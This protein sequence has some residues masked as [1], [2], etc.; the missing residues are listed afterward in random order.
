MESTIDKS[1]DRMKEA[2]HTDIKS[3]NELLTETLAKLKIDLV[4]NID[5]A[6]SAGVTDTEVVEEHCLKIVALTHEKLAEHVSNLHFNVDENAS[7]AK[8]FMVSVIK[9]E[10]M[11]CFNDDLAQHIKETVLEEL[12]EDAKKRLSVK[13]IKDMVLEEVKADFQEQ[14]SDH[15]K[16]LSGMSEKLNSENSSV[17]AE[18]RE[19]VKRLE[20]M[21]DLRFKAASRNTGISAYE[22]EE[23]VKG[24]WAEGAKF[25]KNH[26]SLLESKISELEQHLLCNKVRLNDDGGKEHNSEESIVSKKEWAAKEKAL[27]NQVTQLELKVSELERRLPSNEVRLKFVPVARNASPYSQIT[28]AP[29]CGNGANAEKTRKLVVTEVVANESFDE[30]SLGI[31]PAFRKKDLKSHLGMDENGQ[32]SASDSRV[33]KK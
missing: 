9:E 8:V 33:T 32:R 1:I 27:K 2:T 18:L 12:K 22:A 10:I 4:K 25:L 19:E 5:L 21:I 28:M 11:T 26:F 15:E 30:S 16:R 14:T 24:E 31:H 13:Q 7:K 3:T 29:A 17:S 20:E 6:K 23:K